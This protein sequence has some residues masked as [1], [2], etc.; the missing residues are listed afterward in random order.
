MLETEV[1][2]NSE[3]EELKKKFIRLNRKKKVLEAVKKMKFLNLSIFASYNTKLQRN[4]RK[5]I[6]TL[7]R[8]KNQY[9]NKQDFFTYLKAYHYME[10][11]KQGQS[12]NTELTETQ[13]T[14]IINEFKEKYDKQRI[15]Y[16]ETLKQHIELKK[17]N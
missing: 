9:N 2:I 7:I 17:S 15:E 8:Y 1:R 3:L 5:T 4:I 16:E 14:D 11:L 6:L 12:I 10:A 13:C